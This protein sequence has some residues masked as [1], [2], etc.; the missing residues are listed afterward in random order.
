MIDICQYVSDTVEIV[1]HGLPFDFLGG[2]VAEDRLIFQE[3]FEQDPHDFRLFA[4]ATLASEE[5]L[6]IRQP[7]VVSMLDVVQFQPFHELGGLDLQMVLPD[8]FLDDFR[9]CLQALL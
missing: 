7:H 1:G 6:H 2:E 5:R 4:G 3:I 8:Y 9:L